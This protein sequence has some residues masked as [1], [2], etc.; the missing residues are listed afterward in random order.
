MLFFAEVL[1]PR[2]FE[3]G[4]KFF[5]VLDSIVIFQILFGDGSR[6]EFRQWFRG[7]VARHDGLVCASNKCSFCHS[8]KKGEREKSQF[9]GESVPTGRLGFDISI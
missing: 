1:R 6:Q 8:L 9:F 3:L 5:L 7:W 4:E 2:F